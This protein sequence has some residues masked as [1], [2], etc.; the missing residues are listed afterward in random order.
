MISLLKAVILYMVINR[1]ES[2]NAS[3]T[4]LKGSV[5][6]LEQKKNTARDSR[7]LMLSGPPKSGH[8]LYRQRSCIKG[9]TS[10]TDSPKG[11]L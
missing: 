4:C 8:S 5:S 1:T 9:E 3:L 11:Y 6:F 7:N 2:V 10:N